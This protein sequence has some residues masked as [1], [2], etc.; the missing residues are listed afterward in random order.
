M[1][2]ILRR[3][4][5]PMLAALAIAGCA[6][7]PQ[8]YPREES[9]ALADT[10]NTPLGRALAPLLAKHAPRS[11]AYP[12]N[13]GLDAFVA[14]MLL[15]EAATRSLD[16]QYYIWHG[17]TTGKLL[18]HGLRR[19][20]DRGVRVRLLLDDI[21]TAANDTGLQT[22]D[23][24]PNI[25][26]RLFNPLAVRGARTIGML[27]DLQRTNRRMHSKSFTVDNQ[28]TI[29][30]GRNV[31]DE[32]FAARED[33]QMRDFDVVA[34][35]P[36]VAQASAAFDLYWNSPQVYPIGALVSR[37]PSPEDVT[38]ASARLDAFVE[39]QRQG[40]YVQAL[41]NSNLAGKLRSQQLAYFWGEARIAY[42]EPGKIAEEPSKREANL[43]PTLRA[44]VAPATT[45]LLVVSPYFVPGDEGVAALRQMREKGIRVRIVTNSL[46]ATDV[47]SVHSGYQRY[48]KALLAAGI[49]LYELKPSAAQKLDA[50][51]WKHG[52]GEPHA[53]TAYGV[54]GSSRAALHAK[55]LTV[56]R[57]TLFVGSMNL[58]PRSV[59]LNTEIGAIL[60]MPEMA[61]EYAQRLDAEL[62]ESAYRL[63]L[64]PSGGAGS[65]VQLE[66]IALEEGREV[67]YTS[68]PGAS[69]WRRFSAG[70]LSLLPIE[71][72]L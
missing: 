72:Q 31:G 69:F 56:D 43:L 66:W 9:H 17:D 11:G 3:A 42:D 18:L 36:V 70:L 5:V 54:A 44:Q 40:P 26:V 46:A 6:S 29:V 12:L 59:F 22:I 23:A 67:R 50:A 68:D 64:V 33:V 45:E 52:A 16:V 55:T 2:R 27:G 7:L 32:Y 20:A 62:R 14:R 24:H 61:H 57:R 65:S 34:V 47:V 58:D 71:S 35:G 51:A 13:S 19:A 25:E 49:E 4:L 38:A 39:S 15:A 60:E 10:A 21:G 41:S 28:A 48:R 37:R 8:D 53:D 63:A 30:G 1:P